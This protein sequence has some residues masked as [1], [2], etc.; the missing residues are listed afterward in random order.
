MN[1]YFH[2]KVAGTLLVSALLSAAA[3]AISPGEPEAGSGPW[4]V[5]AWFG[6]ETAR[7]AVASWG[8]HFGDY[9]EKGFLL[10]E[11]DAER[12]AALRALG[13]YVELDE[14]RTAWMAGEPGPW[15]P[16]AIPGFP[17]YR[18][19]EETFATMDALVAAHPG[20]VTVVD[21][22]DSWLKTQNVGERLRHAGAETDQQRG[23]RDPSRSCSSR[24]RSTPASTRRPSSPPASPN[25]WSPATATIRTR[26]GCSI[27]TRSTC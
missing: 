19:V 8:D 14:E 21:A 27:T 9:R 18:T 15:S 16:T 12:V 2:L 1:R 10:I 20:L 3:P 26:P 5:R 23:P 24:R 25:G 22:G 13:Y 17:C 6:D 4:M 7:R 11:A